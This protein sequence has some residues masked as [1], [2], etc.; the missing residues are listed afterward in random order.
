MN[1][2]STYA[3]LKWLIGIF[4]C[5]STGFLPLLTYGQL[6]TSF[7][8][9]EL[10]TGLTNSVN[11]EFAPDGR[12]FILD[13]YGELLIY[14]PQTGVKKQAAL[15]NVYHDQEE[16]LLGIA[17]DPQFTTN[18]YVYIHYSPSGISKNRVSRF[19]LAGDVLNLASEVVL[20]EWNRDQASHAA[21]DMDFDSQGN[22]YIAVGDNTNHS[23]YATLNETT[24]AASSERTSSNTNDLRGKI[25]RI[26]PQPNGTYTIPAGNLFPNGVGGRPEIY[27]MGARNPYKIFVDKTNTDWLFWGEVGPDANTASAS[28]PEG[29]DEINL[30]KSAGNYGWPYFSGK[31]QPYL[32]TYADPDFYYDPA[33]P[34]NISK[35][36]TGA[37]DL[38]PAQPAWLDFF[39]QCHLAGPRYYF[40]AALTNAKKLPAAFDKAFFYYDFNSSKVWVAKIDDTTGKLIS[41]EQ[42]APAVVTVT[43]KEGYIDLKIGPDGQLYALEYGAGCCPDN[44]GTGK[45]VRFDY[46]GIDTNLAPK[47]VLNAHVTSG[48][49]PLTVNFS[50]EGTTDPTNDL[51][52]YSWDFQSDEIVDSNVKNPS[53]TYTQKGKFNALL[54]VSDSKGGISMQSITIDAGNNPAKFTFNSPADGGFMSWGDDINF[55]IAVQDTEDGSTTNGTISCSALRITPAMGHIGHSHDDN[56]LNQ[57][58][59]TFN[60]KPGSHDTQGQENIYYVFKAGYTDRDG[61]VS[62]DQVMVHP[63]I[64]EA[65]F[66]SS[67]VN[68]QQIDNTD[69]LGGGMYSVR[70]STDNSYI[71][72]AGR[73]LV[74]MNSV[75][76]RVTS[77]VGGSIEIR[78]DSPTGTLISTASVPITGDLSTWTTVIAPVTNP[79]GKHDLYF[80]FKNAGKTNLLDLNYI[81]FKGAGVS[82]DK[83]PPD[84]YSI[85]A[86]SKTQ[87]SVK[88]N[89]PIT[90]TS[91]EQIAN[92]S[93]NNSI[94]VSSASLQ[95]DRKTVFL[96]T[97]TITSDIEYQLTI[98]NI[99]NEAGISLIQSIKTFKISS[100]ATRIEA[101][102]YFDQFGI[103]TSV[104]TDEG[105][106]RNVGRLEVGNWIKHT[107]TVNA[108][109]TYMF[110]FRVAGGGVAAGQFQVRNANGVVLNTVDVPITGGWQNWVTVSNI[111]V[112]LQAGSQ[113]IEFISTKKDWGFNWFE[114]TTSVNNSKP[115]VALTA[116]VTN[117]SYTAP[118]TIAISANAADTDG[119]VSKVEFYNG[120]TK[121]GEDLTSPYSYSWTNVAAGTYSLTAKAFDNAAGTTTSAAV[122]VNVTPATITKATRIEAEA[123]TSAFGINTSTC[124]DVGG[125]QNVGRLEVGNWIKHTVTVSSAGTYM[126]NFRVAGGGIAAGQF[127]IRDANGVVLNTVD[128][129]ITGGWQNWVTVSNIPVTL[130]AGS[131]T[132]EFISTKKDWNFNWFEVAP[133]PII[134]T[135]KIE[136]EAFT[137]AFGI[138]TSTCTDVGGG[139]NVGRLEIGN[140]I[141]HTV[142]VSAAGTYMF[143]FRLAAA[144]VAPGQFQ[145]RDANGVVLNTV[146][147]PITGGWQN[148]VTVSNIPVTLKAGSQTIEFISTKKDWN[149]N[150]FEI[151]TPVNNINSQITSSKSSFTENFVSTTSVDAL[152]VYP[153]PTLNDVQVRFNSLIE[154]DVTINLTDV[155]GKVYK[156]L[157]LRKSKG[158]IIQTVSLKGLNEGIYYIQLEAT[159]IKE[160]KK[161][162]KQ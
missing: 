33:K 137:S 78:A 13:R 91:A 60:L 39:H 80:V 88:F 160:V 77:L 161:I 116:P 162:V 86:L 133:E 63:K 72:F 148:W 46:T 126:F 21:G 118:A 15:F 143:N 81:E 85:T 49:L 142:T 61:R 94:T 153:N 53:F 141:K 76:Y 113:T 144:G 111:P 106:G 119:T 58:K 109:G 8:K 159:G 67:E 131:Q 54:R 121:L 117:T 105:G 28:G 103:N 64:M 101:E 140:W 14:K 56:T 38:P 57:C 10:I 93:I 18:K 52:T 75:A 96:N 129:P 154:D 55:D 48:S 82:I 112:V 84:V 68:I 17:F 74:N 65:E 44:V 95:A 24:A 135:T 150:W 50:S 32:N 102:A 12:I 108:A 123:F 157:A 110:N 62:N 69:Q 9:V 16:G 104:C 31:N 23:A 4:I 66:R 29:K 145:V 70:A 11:F 2:L 36:N 73:N 20:L 158:E 25:L 107:V 127:Q 100:G 125:G 42:L 128:V 149:F 71:V 115:T 122:S 98:M 47:I 22:L 124:T 6:P 87:V 5:F 99:Q 151:V 26:K 30:V 136:A 155:N 37:K 7:N 51:L 92:Y 97:S 114:F 147:V 40:D 146:D 79:G 120:T 59:G 27:V 35:W 130:K 132:I 41:T 156:H 43:G 138:N 34:V 1:R 3:L 89:E 83:T 139:Q 90:K 134:Q 152:I 45:L 19:T